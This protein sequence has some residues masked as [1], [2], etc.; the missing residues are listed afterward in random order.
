MKCLQW[1]IAAVVLKVACHMGSWPRKY[2]LGR[3][4]TP[5]SGVVK[6]GSHLGK[7]RQLGLASR[8]Q[9]QGYILRYH[10]DLY[11]CFGSSTMEGLLCFSC[12]QLPM[13]SGS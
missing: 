2:N 4:S 11:E 10:S 3:R 12:S 9:I 5:G 13:D 7:E 1:L 8:T 6:D